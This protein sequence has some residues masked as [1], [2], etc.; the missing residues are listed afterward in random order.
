[1]DN[2]FGESFK[3]LQEKKFDELDK[4]QND[5][6]PKLLTKFYSLTD[7]EDLNN[8]KLSTLENQQIW[9]SP[10]KD[11]NDPYEFRNMYLDKSKF[12]E[13]GFSNKEIDNF[14]LFFKS[15]T[16][17]FCTTSFTT[18][19]YDNLPMWAYYANNSNGFCV[20]YEVVFPGYLER[21]SYEP[22]RVPI[23]TLLI[24]FY[25]EAYEVTK[26]G[27]KDDSEL[28]KLVKVFSHQAL[29]K[30]KSWSHENEFRIIRPLDKG[31][32]ISL[33]ELGLKTK[34][35]IAG[36]NCS[37]E[38]KERLNNISHKLSCGDLLYTRISDNDY[39]LLEDYNG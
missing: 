34:R 26:Q 18:N 17:D 2:Y 33:S 39:T 11:L 21:V 27:K 4:F 35:I 30:H 5:H 38:H 23:S 37:E 12:K 24:D 28:K 6:T 31:K 32:N 7:N 22:K 15:F 14:N 19:T 10:I 36:L 20:E 3:L 13:L 16:S 8:L 9:F 29:M 1:M 25:D